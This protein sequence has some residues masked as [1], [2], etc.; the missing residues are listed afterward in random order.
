[1]GQPKRTILLYELIKNYL[2]YK[3]SIQSI[4]M[5]VMNLEKLV[6]AI[7]LKCKLVDNEYCL[8]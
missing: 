8:V 3:G 1:M 6:D 4:K 5:N 2:I 7:L